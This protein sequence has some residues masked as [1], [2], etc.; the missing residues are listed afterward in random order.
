[1]RGYGDEKKFRRAMGDVTDLTDSVVDEELKA[2]AAAKRPAPK[3]EVEVEADGEE[4][5]EGAEL[6]PDEVERLRELLAKQ[7]G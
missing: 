1:M 3:V 7:G 5:G 2:M 6:T 4:G